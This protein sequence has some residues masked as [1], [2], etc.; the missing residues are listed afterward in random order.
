MR[1]R[2]QILRPGLHRDQE[3]LLARANAS[4]ASVDACILSI[5]NRVLSVIEAGG[6]WMTIFQ[7]AAAALS[8]LHLVRNALAYDLVDVARHART[9]TEEHIDDHL[10]A[11]RESIEM[12]EATGPGFSN[13]APLPWNENPL[14]A[15]MQLGDIYR[16]V[17]SSG[18][19]DRLEAMTRLASAD[20]LAAIIA[21]GWQ[22]GLTPAAIARQ[23]RPAVQG[24]QS[25]A[26]RIARTEGM[27]I[28]HDVQMD[29]YEQVPGIIGYQIH[30]MHFP[31]TRDWHAKRNGTI[32]YRD[33]KPGQKG[34][35]QMPRPPMEAPDPRE[36]PAGTPEVAHNCLCVLPETIVRGNFVAA[37]KAFYSG[38]AVEIRSKLGA[39][40]WLTA[41]H[42]VPTKRGLIAAN[43]LQKSDYLFCRFRKGI[44]RTDD[45][46]YGPSP[47]KNVFDSIRKSGSILRDGA[48]SPFEFH[49]DA[50]NFKGKIQVVL[51]ER[52][53]M[54]RDESM[55]RKFGNQL[56]LVRG[57][58]RTM[59][60]FHPTGTR[61]VI[62]DERPFPFLGI[63]SSAKYDASISEDA[64]QASAGL[65]ASR[66]IASRYAEFFG[67]SLHRFASVVPLDDLVEVRDF[68]SSQGGSFDSSSK[69]AKASGFHPA[70]DSIGFGDTAECGERYKSLAGFVEPDEIIDVRSFHYDGPVYDLQSPTGFYSAGCEQA[71]IQIK[72][73]WLTPVMSAMGLAATPGQVYGLRKFAEEQ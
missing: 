7:S 12:F 72:N 60:V 35:D 39:C 41:N 24:V 66:R 52:E 40:L 28:A 18:W 44:D 51:S 14:F 29:M 58:S 70:P 20:A 22:Q 25:S 48:V 8:K 5:W 3:R 37:S 63:G 13:P 1:R 11:L 45:E 34:F 31:A 55:L 26:R 42:P 73:C 15:P 47:I 69:A 71:M 43:R 57:A 9:T 46:E 67:K 54:A 64:I 56:V 17:Y 16:I 68:D 33:P 32:Y 62:G 4:A 49:G 36:R 27:R 65:G 2:S 6:N 53:L 21:T 38:E 59:G 61:S 50:V 19:Q 30:S 10:P 23:I